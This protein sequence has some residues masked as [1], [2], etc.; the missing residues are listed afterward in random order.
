VPCAEVFESLL[1]YVDWRRERWASPA[2]IKGTILSYRQNVVFAPK[3][4]L[5]CVVNLLFKK[6]RDFVVPAY[7]LAL[8]DFWEKIHN[9]DVDPE[10]RPLVVLRSYRY[11]LELTFPPSCVS[12]DR[13]S[14]RLSYGT[15]R[16]IFAAIAGFAV[17]PKQKQD[18][19]KRV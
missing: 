5:G 14:L 18:T 1:D 6:A 8:P 11:D 12:Y 10:E 15:Q 3:G 7:E 16:F 13:H 2:T 9:I 17:K 4:E 19:T